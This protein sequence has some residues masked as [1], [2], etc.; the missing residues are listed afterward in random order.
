[1]NW[2]PEPERVLSA[3]SNLSDAELARKLREVGD[4][5]TRAE[6]DADYTHDCYIEQQLWTEM[7]RRHNGRAH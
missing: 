1:M 6:T 2:K 3:I 7:V 5:K 4:R